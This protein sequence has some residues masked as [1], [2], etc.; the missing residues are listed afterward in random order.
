MED[1]IG[2][3]LLDRY[4][5][6][7]FV[8]RG[9]MAEVYRARDLRRRITVAL[10]FLR[11]D[12]AED[13]VFLRRFRREARVLE[14]LQHPNIVRYYGFEETDNLHFLV[15]EFIDGEG[16]R[17]KLS[18][19]ARPLTLAQAL[20]ILEPV[21]NALHYAHAEGIYHCD[22]KPANIMI[23]R[24]GRVVVADFGIAKLAESA[25][26]TS[27]TTGTPAYMAPEQCRGQKVDARTDIYALAITTFEMLTLDRPFTGE[28]ATIQGAVSERIR[29]EQLKATPPSPRKY[30]PEIPE[31]AE[32]AILKAL[33][34]QRNRRF[35]SVLAF[36]DA[37]SNGGK[38]TPD[39]V[40]PWAE[41][42]EPEA[43]P[44]TLVEPATPQGATRQG[45]WE[46]RM[47]DAIWAARRAWR[48]AADACAAG[49]QRVRALATR[50]A[51]RVAT[52]ARRA[53]DFWTQR[54]AAKPALAYMLAA[55]VVLL[56]VGAAAWALAGKGTPAT[57]APTVAPAPTATRPS[58][59]PAPT[60][61]D[62]NAIYA[63]IE[64]E[65]ANIR[66]GPATVYPIIS[67]AEKVQRFQV[68]ARSPKSDW[69][70]ICCIQGKSGWVYQD[71]VKIWGD[72]NALPI[73]TPTPPP[74]QQI[75]TTSGGTGR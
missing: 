19:L 8:G 45:Q 50:P 17:K 21:C 16:L 73:S 29:W 66:S 42:G 27:S 20:A 51:R 36:Y 26:V 63:S 49:A 30:N 31:W 4:Y 75:R 56:I 58:P 69:F 72:M 37:L 23:D 9:G 54:R 38:V 24:T 35:P 44:P 59:T 12:M 14:T 7:D 74:P 55:A 64:T 65:K 3:T 71:R 13:E 48:R 67:V 60:P 62:E 22:I 39:P 28:M 43:T 6:E 61:V 34:K 40:L 46:Q 53:S 41:E 2:Q 33:E 32:Q 15:V 5:V 68:I 25:T 11:E 10:K 70:E 1:L 47:T 52:A 57:T 18:R